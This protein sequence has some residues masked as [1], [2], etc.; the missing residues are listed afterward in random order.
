M[1]KKWGEIMLAS[2]EFSQVLDPSMAA[3]RWAGFNPASEAAIEAAEARLGARLPR[4]YRDFLKVSNG[5][6]IGG[7]SGPVRLWP[8]EEIRPLRET[9]PDLVAG[10]AEMS[11]S[12]DTWEDGL[13]PA[14]YSHAI[15]I[16]DDNDGFYLLNPRKT[17]R[18]EWQAAFYANWVPGA[19]CHDSFKELMYGLYEAFT[20]AHPASG[21]EPKKRKLILSTPPAVRGEDPAA[22][23][24]D[25]KR[26]GF[27]KYAGAQAAE[28]MER[29]FFANSEANKLR[30]GRRTRGYSSPGAAILTEACGRIA[31]LDCARLATERARY[32]LEVARG[33]LAT[34][35]VELAQAQ[36]VSGDG[37][38]GAQLEG[39]HQQFF[40]LRNGH[41]A[42]L[43]G[44]HE[45]NAAR[46]VMYE[47]AK[48]VNRVLQRRDRDERIATLEQWHDDKG[49]GEGL[50]FVMLDDELSYLFMWSGA[51]DNFCRPMRGDAF[52]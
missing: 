41:P 46:Y 39:I 36:E 1:L 10:W 43:G 32:G 52:R 21:A 7:T 28:Q 8:V 48:L 50:A 11:G 35:G 16:S 9:C 22:F 29:E 49:P 51:I 5:W 20:A 38:Y 33:L 12:D 24:G 4:S 45:V 6:W 26:L 23:M 13:A 15:Q 42:K 3:K 47:C 14:H 34:A 37:V 30:E 18:G 27:F 25:L 19:E 2:G 44:E 17:R 40:R 31:R